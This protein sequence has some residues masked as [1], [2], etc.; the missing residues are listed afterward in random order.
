ME[1]NSD[2]AL[3][4]NQ[5]TTYYDKVIRYDIDAPKDTWV[6]ESVSGVAINRN[7]DSWALLEGELAP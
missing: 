5:F 1:K 6:I 4:M 3:L 2:E 7:F